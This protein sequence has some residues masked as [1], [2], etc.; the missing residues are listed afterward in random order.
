M[1]AERNC[2]CASALKYAV[3]TDCK[4]I[5]AATREKLGLVAGQIFVAS[6]LSKSTTDWPVCASKSSHNNLH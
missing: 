2:G 6:V 5:P 3:L 1:P 4:V